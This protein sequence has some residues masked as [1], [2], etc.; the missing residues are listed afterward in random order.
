MNFDESF[1]M[2]AIEEARAAAKIGEVPIGAIAVV[3][4]KIVGRA[5]NIREKTHNPLG[6][7]ELLLI[8]K[9]SKRKKEWRLEDAAIYVTCEPCIMCAGAM[10][11]ARIS[12]AVFGCADPKG[13]AFGTIYDVSNDPRL[14]HRIAVVR[15][16][17]ADECASLLSDFFRALRCG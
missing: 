12:K 13:G 15:G 16:V 11:Q 4:E 6:H 14:N 3:G 7:A 2:E 17:L 9:L 1:M 10:L 5:H 8:E